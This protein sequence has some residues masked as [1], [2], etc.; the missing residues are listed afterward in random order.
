MIT[1]DHDYFPHIVDLIFDY[2]T[3]AALVPMAKVCRAWRHRTLNIFYQITNLQVLKA[4]GVVHVS[5]VH[6]RLG[7]VTLQKS[8]LVLL[9]GC[10]VTDITYYRR[11]ISSWFLPSLE[12]VRYHMCQVAYPPI[13]APQL[14][15]RNEM[16]DLHVGHG[17][18]KRLTVHIAG[19]CRQLTWEV[20]DLDIFSGLEEVVFIFEDK[21]Y[22]DFYSDAHEASSWIDFSDSDAHLDHPLPVLSAIRNAI[23]AEEQECATVLLVGTEW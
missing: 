23:R 22:S 17:Q 20:G 1:I 15:F 11:G 7:Q 6:W 21:P 9:A 2:A 12:T 13:P 3:T 4:P 14:V 18:V 5:L 10:K 8:E 16:P 19:R